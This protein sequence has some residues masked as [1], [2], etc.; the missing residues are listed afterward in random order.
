MIEPLSDDFSQLQDFIVRVI[1]LDDSFWFC[2]AL[3]FYRIRIA[4]R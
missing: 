1:M 2:T 3:F 4:V